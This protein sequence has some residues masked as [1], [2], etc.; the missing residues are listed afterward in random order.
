MKDRSLGNELTGFELEACR[1][2]R[3]YEKCEEP[4]CQEIWRMSQET[5]EEMRALANRKPLAKA[6]W[7]KSE[8]EIELEKR[9]Q[10]LKPEDY[11][12]KLPDK[13]PDRDD[14]VAE[15]DQVP[16]NNNFRTVFPNEETLWAAVQYRVLTLRERKLLK[17]YFESDKNLP[18]YKRWKAIGNKIGCSDK[19]VARDFKKLVGKFLKKRDDRQGLGERPNIMA[20]HVRGERGVHFYYRRQL[21]F[22]QWSRETRELITDRATLRELC[23]KTEFVEDSEATP[24]PLSSTNRLF[25]GL[26]R[27][28]A[29]EIP[30]DES[31]VPEGVSP[32]DWEYNLRR[33]RA[34]LAAKKNHSGPWTPYEVGMLFAR[35]SRQCAAC[36]TNLIL[37]FRIDGHRITRSRRFCDDACKMKAERITKKRASTNR[38]ANP[39]IS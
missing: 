33:G 19:T 34:L 39:S 9:A 38:A 30:D 18:A 5:L 25:A 13:D 2:G 32:A 10:D 16:S 20:V 14:D 4:Q 26:I 3:S 27:V 22:G 11:E 31:S 8:Y 29:T 35:H 37:G 36:R 23:K 1:H 12:I 7:S 24:V 28:F 17:A 21:R 15:P 6:S